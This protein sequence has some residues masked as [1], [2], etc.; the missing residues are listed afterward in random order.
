MRWFRVQKKTRHQSL[1]VFNRLKWIGHVVWTA[2]GMPAQPFLAKPRWIPLDE[3]KTT[4]ASWG[5]SK[6][7][8]HSVLGA[9]AVRKNI[10][11]PF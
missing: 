8:W 6:V 11:L 10:E 4:N 7:T 1:K 3:K 5:E 9:R 2:V